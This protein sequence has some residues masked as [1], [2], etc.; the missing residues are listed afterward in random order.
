MASKKM[1][2]VHASPATSHKNDLEI[3]QCSLLEILVAFEIAKIDL[4]KTMTK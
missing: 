1:R 4:N 3:S 2:V